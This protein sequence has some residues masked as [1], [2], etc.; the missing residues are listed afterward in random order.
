[1]NIKPYKIKNQ[2]LGKE[3]EKAETSEGYLIVMSRLNNGTLK[4]STFT[5][6]FN[7]LD[8]PECL[9]HYNKLLAKEIGATTVEKEVLVKKKK[10]LPPRY[11]NKKVE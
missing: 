3:L 8:I 6:R 10:T 1:M 2:K 5:Q 9:V 4:H 11:K 7:R